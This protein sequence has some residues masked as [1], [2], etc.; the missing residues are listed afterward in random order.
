MFNHFE[1]YP[2]DWFSGGR[3]SVEIVED[4]GVSAVISGVF[5]ANWT[6]HAGNIDNLTT[7]RHLLTFDGLM[8]FWWILTESMIVV[9]SVIPKQCTSI[10]W[11]LSWWKRTWIEYSRDFNLALN[12]F[13]TSKLSQSFF[14]LRPLSI[15]RF[16]SFFDLF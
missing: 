1:E 2:M 12:E 8:E 14:M 4:T 11:S 3:G 16:L 7:K 6:S 10:Y 13:S 5:E 15:L 9:R